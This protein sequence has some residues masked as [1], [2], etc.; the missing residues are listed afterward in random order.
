MKLNF[1]RQAV[2]SK[3]TPLIV[4]GEWSSGWIKWTTS[5][6]PGKRFVTYTRIIS[7][8]GKAGAAGHQSRRYQFRGRQRRG[9]PITER[10]GGKT[11]SHV[12]AGH[13]GPS[14]QGIGSPG[15]PSADRQQHQWIRTAKM[16]SNSR[17]KWLWHV[18]RTA[19]RAAYA[20]LR[21]ASKGRVAA[22][23]FSVVGAAVTHF[24]HPGGCGS[25]R[26]QRKVTR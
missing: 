24:S 9:H 16:N 21:P 15:I 10:D 13:A 22:V 18:S 3:N 14:Q 8:T 2:G 7:R 26:V 11:A 5:I 6:N 4:S 23:L 20:F 12:R 17:H 1:K 19:G 25:A